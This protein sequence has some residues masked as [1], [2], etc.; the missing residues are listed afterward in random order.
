MTTRAEVTM[1]RGVFAASL[2]LLAVHGCGEREGGSETD[3]F[4]A[5]GLESHPGHR[6]D[7]EGSL[8]CGVL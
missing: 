5:N 8:F 1:K 7:V 6:I 3:S 2:A 4:T